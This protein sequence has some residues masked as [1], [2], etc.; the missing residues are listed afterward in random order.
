MSYN[1]RYRNKHVSKQ[2]LE[3]LLG[4]MSLTPELRFIV[5]FLLDTK[6]NQM[7]YSGR[8]RLEEILLTRKCT[9]SDEQELLRWKSKYR[10]EFLRYMGDDSDVL[11][12]DTVS[13]SKMKRAQEYADTLKKVNEVGKKKGWYSAMNVLSAISNPLEPIFNILKSN[14]DNYKELEEPEIDENAPAPFEEKP[15]WKRIKLW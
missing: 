7:E 10:S 1:Q 4:I 14:K 12:T 11:L 2:G 5:K 6:S 13:D 8:S 9:T 15:L 3:S